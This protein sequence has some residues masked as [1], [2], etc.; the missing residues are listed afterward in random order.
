MDTDMVPGTGFPDFR[1]G[2]VKHARDRSLKNVLNELRFLTNQLGN[3]FAPC[4]L[5]NELKDNQ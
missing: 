5:L 4:K 1:G 2:V 3:R